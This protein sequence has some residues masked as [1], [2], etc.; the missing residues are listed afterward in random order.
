LSN[1][2]ESGSTYREIS[3][4]YNLLISYGIRFIYA[5]MILILGTFIA[6]M[7]TKGFRR[8]LEK[9]K[10]EITIA[11][12][13]SRLVQA[14]LLIFVVLA[15][16]SKLGVQTASLVAILGA[17]SLAVGLS[18]KSSLSNLASG[19]LLVVF[20]PFKIGDH[21]RIGS[22]EGTIDEI[23]LLFTEMVSPDNQQITIPNSKFMS[24]A[25]I[26]HSSKEL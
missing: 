11:N 3:E 6:K 13:L 24:D 7:I 19:L 9:R 14:L 1:Q 15:T 12:F 22:Y 10:V 20:R 8:A 4:V 5:L 18:L 2:N 25:I 16:L 26:N 17:M 21:I 23:S